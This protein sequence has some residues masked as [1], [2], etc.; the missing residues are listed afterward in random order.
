M[1]MSRVSVVIPNYNREH[2]IGQT[3]ENMLNQ[4]VPPY[5]VI[6]VDD[7]STDDSRE[8]IRSFGDRIHLI[9]QSNQ[10]PGAARN[11]G[12]AA[13]SG[14]YIQFMDS[15]DLA[16]LNKL[17]VQLA[18]L[19]HSH[20]DFAYCSWVRSKIEEDDICFLGPVMQ[21]GPLPSWKPMLEWQLGSWCLV[22]QN[23]LFRREA[24]ERA[25]QY[26]TDLMPTED[27]EYLV[28]I[29]AKQA[30]PVYT[31]NCTVFYRI[32]GKGQ[33][34]ITSSGTQ[35]QQRAKD[36]G[37]YLEIVGEQMSEYL[38]R[39]HRSTR[40]EIALDIYRHNRYCQQMNWLG[41]D[42]TSPFSRLLES[43]PPNYM[44]LYD[45]WERF[46]RKL[47]LLSATTPQSKGLVLRPIGNYEKQ[48]AQ[49]AGLNVKKHRCS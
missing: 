11:R 29:L 12:L 20:A 15:D 9:E 25:G 42:S 3:L 1:N 4:S 17:E 38:S 31:G 48:L 24:L 5:E 14:D 41:V 27:S 33:N 46:N 26:R 2:L 30:I 49:Q 13:S 36:R 8:V 34:Q 35:N 10:G 19:H 37:R 16:S 43:M 23:C 40:R 45:W 18:A 7:G 22:F 39:F 28:R 21:G 44:R 47:S 6:V 32:D